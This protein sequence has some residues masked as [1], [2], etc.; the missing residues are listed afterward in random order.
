[1]AAWLLGAGALLSALPPSAAARDQA[2]AVPPALIEPVATLPVVGLTLERVQPVRIVAL[3][4]GTTQGMGASSPAASFP[5]RLQA[6]LQPRVA[7]PV[8][9]INQG[10]Q[11]QTA[12]EMLARL[13][14]DVLSYKP[15]LVLWETGTVDAVRGVPLDEFT[16]LL[17]AGISRLRQAGVDIMLID[18]QYA[19]YAP[20]VVNILP[21]VEAMRTVAGMGQLV[22]FDRFEVMRHWVD[23]NVFH[24]DERAPPRV[25]MGE[26]DQ[27]Y[28]CIAEL[29]ADVIVAAPPKSSHTAAK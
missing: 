4:S 23:N 29:L 22:L 2:C 6:A 15:T 17:D 1:M 11:R 25:V 10:V 14:R 16:A 28:N 24:L 9:V 8:S 3:G 7:A 18:P 5:M 20:R 12:Q 21:F 26:I 27:V 19:R 13:E